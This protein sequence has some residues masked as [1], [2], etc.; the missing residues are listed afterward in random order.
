M[1]HLLEKLLLALCEEDAAHEVG[2]LLPVLPA[3]LVEQGD[4]IAG[5]KF[6]ARYWFQHLQ[7]AR[8]QGSDR[9]QGAAVDGHYEGVSRTGDVTAHQLLLHYPYSVDHREAA[10]HEVLVPGVLDVVLDPCAFDHCCVA[11]HCEIVEHY[12]ADELAVDHYCLDLAVVF[13]GD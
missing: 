3:Q 2:A 8:L 5:L 6:A 11:D 9:F 13:A 1:L 7:F 4:Q 10:D 12:V